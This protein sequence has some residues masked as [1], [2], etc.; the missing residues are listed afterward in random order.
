MFYTCVLPPMRLQGPSASL[1]RASRS[2]E[3]LGLSH[4]LS[5][6]HTHAWIYIYIYTHIQPARVLMFM[7][8][9]CRQRPERPSE[10]LSY[11]IFSN[12]P[13]DKR[14]SNA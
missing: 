9:R 11:F 4:T 14:K 12:K 7:A 3:P 13:K 6:M 1:G 2:S 8:G 10:D 5:H